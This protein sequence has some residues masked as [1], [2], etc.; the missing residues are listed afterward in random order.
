MQRVTAKRETEVVFFNSENPVG[1]PQTVPARPFASNWATVQFGNAYRLHRATVVI[2]KYLLLPLRQRCVSSS[3]QH[4]Y[5][6]FY[7]EGTLIVSSCCNSFEVGPTRSEI[8]QQCSAVKAAVG[9]VHEL[10][11]V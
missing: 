7:D 6:S 9:K 1:S 11:A 3:S 2:L 4:K 8:N 5:P 10:G